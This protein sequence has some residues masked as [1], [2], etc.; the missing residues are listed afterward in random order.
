MADVIAFNM[1]HDKK[2]SMWL[3]IAGSMPLHLFIKA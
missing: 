2:Y 1:I 3:T